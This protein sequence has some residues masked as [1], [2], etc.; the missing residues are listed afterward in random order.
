MTVYKLRVRCDSSGC[1]FEAVFEA[2][3]AADCKSDAMSAGWNMC[4]WLDNDYWQRCP[5]CVEKMRARADSV[6][7]PM[8]G[9]AEAKR[10]RSA[11]AEGGGL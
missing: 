8:A 5:A 2:A 7:L 10:W 1:D 6:A 3:T 9:S 4:F 11:S